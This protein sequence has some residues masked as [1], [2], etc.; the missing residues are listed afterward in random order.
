MQRARE[1]W[2]AY[3]A[4]RRAQHRASLKTKRAAVRARVN[5]EIHKLR[6][7]RV[8]LRVDAA[9]TALRVQGVARVAEAQRRRNA[10]VR[11]KLAEHGAVEQRGME[12]IG[13]KEVGKQDVEE[14]DFKEGVVKRVEG[15]Y[16]GKG[17][18]MGGRMA[19]AV[20]REA[21]DDVSLREEMDDTARTL[22]VLVGV[23]KDAGV[24]W[25]EMEKLVWTVEPDEE[26]R[27]ELRKVVR[28]AMEKEGVKMSMDVGNS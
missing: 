19:S 2:D 16:E 14:R 15:I 6:L 11:K 10:A 9:Q 8:M 4:L 22:K 5:L 13:L 27:K 3:R 18:V 26:R 12:S 7:E 24:G 21:V 23:A 17:G 20:L 25:E 1:I 28:T